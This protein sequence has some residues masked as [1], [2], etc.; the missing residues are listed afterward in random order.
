MEHAL[1]KTIESIDVCTESELLKLKVP[2]IFLGTVGF[3]LRRD[4]RYS[5]TWS[6]EQVAVLIWRPQS[7]GRPLRKLPAKPD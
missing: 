7:I 6:S 2:I 4:G 5:A 3:S 1:Y